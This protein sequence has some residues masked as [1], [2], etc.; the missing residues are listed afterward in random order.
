MKLEVGAQRFPISSVLLSPL[1]AAASAKRLDACSAP[2]CRLV[3]T[4]L[5]H[6]SV[7]PLDRDMSSPLSPSA[8]SR[9]VSPQHIMPPPPRADS[10]AV[11]P[12]EARCTLSLSVRGCCAGVRDVTCAGPAQRYVDASRLVTPRRRQVLARYLVP[13]GAGWSV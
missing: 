12:R 9:A 11:S 3:S 10:R 5:D 2:T 8:D 7:Y 13:P 6:G 4:R 1:E